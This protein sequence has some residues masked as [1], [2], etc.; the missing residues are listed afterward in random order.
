[1]KLYLFLT[2]FRQYTNINRVRRYL[3]IK[4]SIMWKLLFFLPFAI[5]F[6]LRIILCRLLNKIKPLRPQAPHYFS[7]FLWIKPVLKFYS[8]SRKVHV[9]H[10]RLFHKIVHF[11]NKGYNLPITRVEFATNLIEF[12]H[13]RMQTSSK[14]LNSINFVLIKLYHLEK[15]RVYYLIG[16]KTSQ[17]LTVF[18]L[19]THQEQIFFAIFNYCFKQLIK[20]IIQ[21]V[22]LPCP[23]DYMLIIW[24]AKFYVISVRRRTNSFTIFLRIDCCFRK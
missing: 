15:N 12:D 2:D 7:M 16:F 17:G 8:F 1:M 10:V 6:L 20:E 5:F 19:I 13:E 23:S 21:N 11:L 18:W 14:K 22:F 4:K 9:C 24:F 3:K